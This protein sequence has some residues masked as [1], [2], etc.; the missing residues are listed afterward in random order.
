MDAC[1]GACRVGT[2]VDEEPGGRAQGDSR[3][4]CSYARHWETHGHTRTHRRMLLPTA[5]HTLA[6]ILEGSLISSPVQ[7]VEARFTQPLR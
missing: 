7:R 6:G 5:T 2:E 1:V 4:L 3:A